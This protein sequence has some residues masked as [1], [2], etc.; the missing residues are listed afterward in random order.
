MSDIWHGGFWPHVVRAVHRGLFEQYFGRWQSNL[1]LYFVFNYHK[2]RS[3]MLSLLVAYPFTVNFTGPKMFFA[4]PNFLS[5][6]KNL[7]AYFVSHKHFVPD[8]K[9]ICIQQFVF[10]EALNAVKFLG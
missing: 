5:Q 3:S 2:V 7:F 6:P 9:M 4:N 1:S 10:E 8:K